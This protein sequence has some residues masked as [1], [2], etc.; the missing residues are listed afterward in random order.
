MDNNDIK[1]WGPEQALSVLEQDPNFRVLRR[2]DPKELLLLKEIPDGAGIGLVL[3]TETTGKDATDRIIELGMVGFAYDRETGQVY[4]ALD[5]YNELEDPGMAIPAEATAV[6][7]ITDKMVAGKRMDDERVNAMVELADFCIA[8]NSGFDRPKCEARFPVFKNKAWACS[9]RQ[10]DWAGEGIGSAKLDY[11]A[12]RRG[13]FFEAH[14]AYVDGLALLKVLSMPMQ[15]LGGKPAL[16]GLLECYQEQSH[17]VWAVN[18]P[19]ETKDALKA[20]GYRWSDGSKEGTEKAWHT[21]VSAEAL[22][23]ELAWLKENVYRRKPFALPV[24]THDAYTRFSDRS[25]E[26]QTKYL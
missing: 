8:H 21:D 24:D 5:T 23:E 1:Q 9:F 3:D 15:V 2:Y 20:R 4:G 12:Y 11:I 25:G 10:L 13:F 26:R 16:S 7:G 19:F 18:S 17:R 14:R 22:D 6:N